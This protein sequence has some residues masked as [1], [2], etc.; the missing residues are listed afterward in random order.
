MIERLCGF[1]PRWSVRPLLD[2]R[3]PPGAR[4]VARARPLHLHHVSAEVAER[5][6]AQRPGEDARKI[7]DEQTVEGA[8][9][10]GAGQ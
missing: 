9:H 8:G 1:R 6:R 3:R 10:G 7:G 5:L 4:V 2:E